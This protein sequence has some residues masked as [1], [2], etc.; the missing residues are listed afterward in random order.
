M[1]ASGSCSHRGR[2]K[3]RS[4]PRVV[5]VGVQSGASYFEGLFR[6]WA[7]ITKM[8]M[9]QRS[10]GQARELRLEQRVPRLTRNRMNSRRIFEECRSEVNVTRLQRNFE[11]NHTRVYVSD[12]RCS[13]LVRG[14]IALFKPRCRAAF[15][16]SLGWHHGS[17]SF[18]QKRFT[19][20][21]EVFRP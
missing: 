9:L 4:K 12:T 18:T 17:F 11:F 2:G 15:I 14:T 13:I 3:A 1:N 21:F 8:V 16:F 5:C 6:E 20:I 10:I 19:K 7:R